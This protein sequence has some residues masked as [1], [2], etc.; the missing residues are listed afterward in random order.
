MQTLKVLLHT[1]MCHWEEDADEAWKR[2]KVTKKRAE[3][4]ESTQD[5]LVPIDHGL[6]YKLEGIEIV[7]PLTKK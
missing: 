7:K 6:F 2:P 1:A 4:L 3:L 5:T